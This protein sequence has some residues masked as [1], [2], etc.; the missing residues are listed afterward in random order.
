MVIL[1]GKLYL[2]RTLSE[3]TQRN[4]AP[5]VVS[6]LSIPGNTLKSIRAMIHAPY[7]VLVLNAQPLVASIYNKVID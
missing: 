6:C 5:E 1:T 7:T 4:S 2:N 3:S